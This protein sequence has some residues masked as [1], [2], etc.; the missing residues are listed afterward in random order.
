MGHDSAEP[1]LRK[2][3]KT[4]YHEAADLGWF[5]EQ[6]VELIEGEVLCKLSQSDSH[7]Q[8]LCLVDVAVRACF[9][10][11]YVFCI[12]MPLNV[13]GDSEPEPDLAVVRG[14][15][16]SVKKHPTSAS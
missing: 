5:A 7:A 14:T 10:E 4:E 16:R 1:I 8:S 3:T 2:W 12:Q 9:A 11:G 15:P 13:A 6:R